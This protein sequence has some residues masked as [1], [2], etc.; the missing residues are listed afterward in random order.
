MYRAQPSI[1]ME[2]KNPRVPPELEYEGIRIFSVPAFGSHRK[3]LFGGL[4][5]GCSYLVSVAWYVFRDWKNVSGYLIG[6]F[7]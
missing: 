4:V 3:S 5:Y 7:D 2:G 6:C 1:D